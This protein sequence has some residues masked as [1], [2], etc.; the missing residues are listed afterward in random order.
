MRVCVTDAG[1][2]CCCA[3]ERVSEL[4]CMALRVRQA[5]GALFERH[6]YG[7][8]RKEMEKRSAEAAEAVRC[9]CDDGGGG[10]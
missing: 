9:C 8:R 7:V 1:I 2:V 6:S 10:G 5:V 3:C 4:F